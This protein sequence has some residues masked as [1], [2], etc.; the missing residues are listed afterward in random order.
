MHAKYKSFVEYV[1]CKFFHFVACL[2][3]FLRELH[4]AKVS[5]FDEA[6]FIN[7]SFYGLCFWCPNI[8]TPHPSLPGF[9][10]FFFFLKVFKVLL[11]GPW[12]VFELLFSVSCEVDLEIHCL[13]G[14]YVTAVAWLLKRPSV[15]YSNS[16]LI[17]IFK[18]CFSLFV[19]IGSR[20]LPKSSR[21]RT[22]WSSLWR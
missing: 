16:F 10:F 3:I 8:R 18:Y 15:H 12:S 4:R 11:L 2:F 20:T 14:S 5:N 1:A 19:F 13:A 7:F 6:Q 22:K 21:R 9:F 17:Q